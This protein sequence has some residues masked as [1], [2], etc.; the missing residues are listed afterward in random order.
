MLIW[1]LNFNMAL[2]KKLTD[3]LTVTAKKLFDIV[4][5]LFQIQ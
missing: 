4:Y 5:Y 3:E 2:I 1:C